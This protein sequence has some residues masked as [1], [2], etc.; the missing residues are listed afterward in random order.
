MS[1]AEKITA[2]VGLGSNLDQPLQ[3]IQQAAT[4]L[5]QIPDTE[6]IALSPL[7]QSSAIGPGEQ[8]DYINAVA[9]LT[10]S[11]SAHQLLHQ[12]QSIENQQGRSRGPERWTART[13][14][15]DLLM[16][17]NDVINTAKLTVPHPRMTERNFVLYPLRDLAHR[18]NPELTLPNGQRI[19]SLADQCK[20]DGIS[21]A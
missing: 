11:L 19:I 8:P 9:A 6:L 12:L 3:H 18:L 17:G 14:D 13:L 10:T 1:D 2:F 21:P 20:N 7:Y 15:L 4:A 5:D 16:F